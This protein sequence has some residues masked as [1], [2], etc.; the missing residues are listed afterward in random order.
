MW[1]SMCWN[2]V[3]S[4]CRN[5]RT[6]REQNV[7]RFIH[8]TID[9]HKPIPSDMQ[10]F[11]TIVNGLMTMM[12][13]RNRYIR[14]II[15]TVN[16]CLTL[17]RDNN[18]QCSIHTTDPTDDRLWC[19]SKHSPNLLISLVCRSISTLLYRLD[20]F[21]HQSQTSVIILKQLY[22]AHPVGCVAADK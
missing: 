2:R 4:C 11:R 6:T 16:C 8:A 22:R 21:C 10:C 7:H 12:F 15:R 20:I 13:F 1:I 17:P 5:V 19:P 18:Y 3:S 14:A 9:C